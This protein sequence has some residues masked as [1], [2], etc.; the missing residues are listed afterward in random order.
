[1]RRFHQFAYKAGSW[2][3]AEKMRF[4]PRGL[5]KE[6]A[7]ASANNGRGPWW[8]AGT[9]HMNDSFRAVYFANLAL[10]SF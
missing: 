4:M 3:S 1:M 8:N 6:R 5:D 2:R 9:S 7:W 10:P